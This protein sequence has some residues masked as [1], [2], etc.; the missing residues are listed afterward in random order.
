M[1]LAR[2]KKTPPN[3]NFSNEIFP[4]YREKSARLATPSADAPRLIYWSSSRVRS[5][6]LFS[7]FIQ[8]CS[9][10]YIC[11]RSITFE[12]DLLP[13]YL[14]TTI[15]NLLQF[16][17]MPKWEVSAIHTM[18]LACPISAGAGVSNC[19]LQKIVSSLVVLYMVFYGCYPQGRVIVR[20]V[21]FGTAKLQDVGT[22][23]SVVMSLYAIIE[24]L[25][26]SFCIHDSC[27]SPCHVNV[28][29][30]SHCLL[31]FAYVCT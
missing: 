30:S 15:K 14:R 4:T 21:T 18:C 8:G 19:N 3:T 1:Y 26:Q 7:V 27:P 12:I 31:F 13:C 29:Q 10:Y 22:P 2:Y 25:S 20:G 6:Y 9:S 23:L 24:L 5:V 16:Y 28:M 17:Y 11:N